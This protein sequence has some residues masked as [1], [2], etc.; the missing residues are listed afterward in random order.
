MN[1]TC[2]IYTFMEKF[3]NVHSKCIH[4]YNV[5]NYTMYT[6]QKYINKTATFH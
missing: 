2:T 1:N 4:I 5:H 3:K 6:I